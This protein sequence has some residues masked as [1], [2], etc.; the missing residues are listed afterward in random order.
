MDNGRGK[1]EVVEEAPRKFDSVREAI[2]DAREKA[3][4]S[5]EADEDS[6]AAEEKDAVEKKETKPLKKVVAK[7][8]DTPSKE[9]GTDEETPDSTQEKDNSEESSTP[10]DKSTSKNQSAIKPPVGWTKAAKDHWNSLPDEI[11]KSVAKR[12][13]EVSNGFKEYGEKTKQLKE[14]DDIVARLT[15]DYQ[16]FGVSKPQL[17]ERTLL[18][19]NSL[20]DNNKQNAVSSLKQ[21]AANFGLDRE[22]ESSYVRNTATAPQDAQDTSTQD[23]QSAPQNEAVNQLQS[24]LDRIEADR[25]TA[26]RQRAQSIVDDWKKDKPHFDKV[27]ASMH[28]LLKN[29]IIPLKP[30]GDFDLDEA[31]NRAV[32]SDPELY[33]QVQSEELAKHKA[34]LETEAKAEREKLRKQADVARSKRANVSLKPN[35]PVTLD[36]TTDKKPRQM[37]VRESIEA[38]KK[39]IRGT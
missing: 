7:K 17:V 16:T 10:E 30:S 34:A 39:E 25:A 23:N 33:A 12:E 2:A 9:A 31:Y 26:E 18:W 14:Y 37:S 35:A 24:R 22:L 13:E 21:L 38:A 5:A 27:R 3:A 6:E 4:K 36:G 15:P 19:L 20:R 8:S 1:K 32:R 28:V 29:N 11:K